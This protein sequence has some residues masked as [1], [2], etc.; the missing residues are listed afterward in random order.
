MM[1]YYS[2]ADLLRGIWK[3]SRDT[4]LVDR[5]IERWEILVK[6]GGYEYL[7]WKEEEVVKSWTKV[8]ESWN[9][10]IERLKELVK[11]YEEAIGG[12]REKIERLEKQVEDSRLVYGNKIW[13]FLKAKIKISDEDYDAFMDYLK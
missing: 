5:M 11:Q 4:R 9:E 10:E 12:Y 7:G 6:E 3:S 1:I 13:K 8:V 2:K